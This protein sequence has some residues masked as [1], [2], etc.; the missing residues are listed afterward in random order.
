[1][2][3]GMDNV[4][5]HEREITA[6]ALRRLQEVPGVR[7]LGP[8]TADDRGGAISFEL[9]D[10]HPHDVSQ[11]L[12]SYG[13]AVRAGH[14]CARP[15][16]ERFGVHASTRASAYLYTTCAEIDALADGLQRVKKFFGVD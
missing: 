1:S 10:L 2:S 12:D 4:A 13:I 6:Y 16:H 8:T 3:L 9:G 15:A 7:I 5:A 11:V 14:H